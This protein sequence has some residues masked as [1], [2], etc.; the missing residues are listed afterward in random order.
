MFRRKPKLEARLT[1]DSEK[2]LFAP[3]EEI[4][5]TV[6]VAPEQDMTR[7]YV[8]I[9]PEWKTSGRGLAEEGKGDGA[10]AYQG[11]LKAGETSVHAFNLTMPS[12]P[13]SYDGKHIQ[14]NWKLAVYVTDSKK[15]SYNNKTICAEDFVLGMGS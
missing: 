9:Q 13:W 4:S 6:E 2:Y 12:E 5:G 11:D 8:T 14:I 1:I 15:P 7:R 10:I 3:G